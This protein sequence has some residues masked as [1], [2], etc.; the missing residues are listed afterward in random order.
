M[1][2]FPYVEVSS[3]RF[4]FPVYMY[5]EEELG[6]V[7]NEYETPLEALRRSFYRWKTA[8]IGL[9]P[10]YLLPLPPPPLSLFSFPPLPSLINPDFCSV[11]LNARREKQ[12]S[13]Y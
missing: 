12:H 2:S 3:S 5:L 1:L 8:I 6:Y 10:L 9:K 13:K 7:K 11:W 4:A